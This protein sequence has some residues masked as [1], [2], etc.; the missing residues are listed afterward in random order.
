[1]SHDPVKSPAHYAR[2]PLQ[3]KDFFMINNLPGWMCNVIKYVMRADAKNGL[4]DLEKAIDYIQQRIDFIKRT[5]AKDVAL[6]AR[7]AREAA[8]VEMKTSPRVDPDFTAISAAE[9]ALYRG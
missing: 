7:D 8:I 1:M 5:S 3:P 2:Y 4:E 6:V 9:A